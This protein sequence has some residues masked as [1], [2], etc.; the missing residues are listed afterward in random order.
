M[1]NGVQRAYRACVVRAHE[2]S[3]GEW[4]ASVEAMIREL[5][6]NLGDTCRVLDFEAAPCPNHRPLRVIRAF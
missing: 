3:A 6:A 5:V 4:R 2:Y 1:V